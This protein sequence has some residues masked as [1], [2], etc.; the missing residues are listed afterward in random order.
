MAKGVDK[1]ATGGTEL[2]E[3]TR[4]NLLLAQKTEVIS[5]LAGAM[6]RA[7]RAVETV[8][9]YR[10]VIMGDFDAAVRAAIWSS[11]IRSERKFLQW[12][13]RCQSPSL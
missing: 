10:A 13:D 6:A 9:A 2:K 3:D 8:I 1:P 11:S 5:D 12:R 4:T 7:G